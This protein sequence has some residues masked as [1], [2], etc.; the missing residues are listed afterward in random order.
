MVTVEATETFLYKDYNKV[1]II[2]KQ[3][4]KVGEF[5]KGDR[6]K[7]NDE[8]AKYLCGENPLNRPVVKVIEIEPKQKKEETTEKLTEK[9]KKKLT[10]R[11]IT[12][13]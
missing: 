4:T 7:C 11:N 9:P 13:E 10:K 6:F 12:K 3:G 8:M 1:E 5:R 2:A